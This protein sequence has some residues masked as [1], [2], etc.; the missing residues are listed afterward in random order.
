MNKNYYI[1]SDCCAS[2][3]YNVCFSNNS[4]DRITINLV[5]YWAIVLKFM[6]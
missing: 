6:Q 1:S 4:F 5:E 2:F 3:N